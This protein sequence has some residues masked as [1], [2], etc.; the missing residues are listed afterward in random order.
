MN[1]T[2]SY[3]AL[4]HSLGLAA[5]LIAAL[6]LVA[7]GGG[8]TSGTAAPVATFT[9]DPDSPLFTINIDTTAEGYDPPAVQIPAGRSIQLILRNRD[10]VEHHYRVVG[11]EPA[12]MLW[13]AQPDDMVREA[14]VTEEDHES[15]HAK[16]FVDFR[17]TSPSGIK[18]TLT[19]VHA[20][21]I[22]GAV[23]VVH[24]YALT[25]GTYEVNDPLHPEIKGTLTVFA[26]Q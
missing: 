26:P 4:P 9:P 1:A 10:S 7:C 2:P 18:P 3:R 11:L 17:G 25:P 24:F 16:D 20:Y 21:A 12:E 5:L 23:D 8:A 6:V 14:G 15:H 22:G 19:E 13:L